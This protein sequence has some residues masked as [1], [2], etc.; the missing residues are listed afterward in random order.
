[1]AWRMFGLL[2]PARVSERK[3]RPLQA[4]IKAGRLKGISG[5]D[6]F[7]YKQDL[8]VDDEGAA[9]DAAYTRDEEAV[10]RVQSPTAVAGAGIASRRL[11]GRFCS[12]LYNDGLVFCLSLP[13]FCKRIKNLDFAGCED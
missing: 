4:E 12:A 3:V 1:M 2:A 5:R 6:L 8:F 10:C 7:T 11:L 9:D 13:L